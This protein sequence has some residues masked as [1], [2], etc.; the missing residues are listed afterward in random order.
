MWRTVSQ[1]R[2]RHVKSWRDQFHAGWR[3]S[4]CCREPGRRLVRATRGTKRSGFRVAPGTSSLRRHRTHRRK[5]LAEI[6]SASWCFPVPFGNHP[7]ALAEA[8]TRTSP[9]YACAEEAQHEHRERQQIPEGE[10]PIGLPLQ[11]ERVLDGKAKR[12]AA[13][14]RERSDQKRLSPAAKRNAYQRQRQRMADDCDRNTR[15]DRWS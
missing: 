10:E 1:S 11:S 7:A 6:A 8:V 3:R 9:A 12:A 2:A 5:E 15:A 4:V 14:E 13:R